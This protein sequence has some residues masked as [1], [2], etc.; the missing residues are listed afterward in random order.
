MNSADRKRK[1]RAKAKE[2]GD[3][4]VSVKLSKLHTERLE[5][6]ASHRGYDKAEYIAL[7]IHRDAEKLEST[8][9]NMGAC[10]FCGEQLPNGCVE[11]WKGHRDCFYTMKVR[12]T[13]SL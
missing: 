5:W 7:L 8:I 12:E 3:S 6:A 10:S 2:R 1:E 13:L 11:K 9:D 4:T